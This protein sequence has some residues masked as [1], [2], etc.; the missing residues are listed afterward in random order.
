M[1]IGIP[2]Y[3]QVD[4]LDV[5][6]PHELFSW[7][8]FDVELVAEQRGPL[9]F[10]NG[11]S[12]NVA[13]SFAEAGPYDVLWVPGGDPCALIKLM[14]D[15][16]YLDFLKNK[17]GAAKFV[18]SVCEGAMLLAAAGLLDG[19]TV[20]THW[21]FY[22]CMARFPKVT[23]ASGYRRYCLDR[24]RLTGGGISSGLDEALMLI[25]LLSGTEK[26]QFV[27]RMTQYYPQ[28]PVTGEITPSDDCPLDHVSAV[29]S[30]GTG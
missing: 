10:R 15:R 14:G 28:P 3:D 23:L 17:S 26:A 22:P 12:F 21:A 5:A 19:Y 9:T 1:L 27:Q 6:G 24:N 16:T 29:R 25:Q 2:V 8:N 7:A 20:T 11:F 30:S 4:M 13:K 18:A